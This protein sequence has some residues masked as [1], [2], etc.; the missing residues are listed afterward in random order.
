[1]LS[2]TDLLG[3]TP[4]KCAIS[5]TGQ[6]M[7]VTF[8]NSGNIILSVDYGGSW[9]IL[10]ISTSVITSV[11]I[12][13]SGQY[14]LVTTASTGSYV[15][16]NYL[17][18]WTLTSAISGTISAVSARGNVMIV[19]NGRVINVSNNNGST[20]STISNTVD[21]NN[22]TSISTSEYGNYLVYTNIIKQVYV[23]SNSGTSWIKKLSSTI[24]G[25]SSKISNNGQIQLVGSFNPYI[26]ISSDYGANWTIV[27]SGGENIYNSSEV[28]DTV[29]YMS[30]S[31]NARYITLYNEY[32]GL[33]SSNDMGNT[34]YNNN[35]TY[36]VVGLA[37]SGNSKYNLL[38]TQN[39]VLLSIS[40]I[41]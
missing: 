11:S 14:A 1:M 19:V 23:S 2:S 25:Q 6:F 21:T 30:A 41:L 13:D 34:F 20:W 8:A 4:S 40:M 39:S 26:F 33:S 31:S 15:S 9:T 37:V 28:S 7:I 29:E 24:L 38:L 32:T 17:S 27:K 16:T 3:G 18:G 36:T 10:N 5:Y 22:I 35:S 12:S